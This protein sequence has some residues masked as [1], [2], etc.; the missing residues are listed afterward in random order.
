MTDRLVVSTMFLRR[1]AEG[2]FGF[3]ATSDCDVEVSFEG[4]APTKPELAVL[5]RSVFT[6]PAAPRPLSLLIRATPK[7][8][9]FW[10][11]AARFEYRGGGEL[12]RLKADDADDPEVFEEAAFQPAL[13][14]DFKRIFGF[15]GSFVGVVVYLSRIREVTPRGLKAINKVPPKDAKKW[16]LKDGWLPA[17][18]CRVRDGVHLISQRMLDDSAQLEWRPPETVAAVG[19]HR[20]F[21]VGE[22]KAPRLLAVSWPIDV[23]IDQFPEFFAPTPFLVYIHPSLGQNA[24]IFSGLPYPFEWAYLFFIG[25]RDMT[26]FN[27]PITQSPGAKGVAY[28]IAAARRKAV[29]VDPISKFGPDQGAA[30]DPEELETYLREIQAFMF[31]RKHA[32]APPPLGRVALAA[33]SNGCGQLLNKLIANPTHSLLKDFVKEIY[34]LDPRMNSEQL[35]GRVLA[36]RRDNPADKRV[37]AYLSIPDAAYLKLIDTSSMPGTPFIRS[38]PD[39]LR[40]M[41]VTSTTTW[42]RSSKALGASKKIVDAVGKFG[43]T[44]ELHAATLIVHA[45]GLSGFDSSPNRPPRFKDLK[46][47]L[48]DPNG[49]AMPGAPFLVI[50][51]GGEPTGTADSAGDAVVVDVVRGSTCKVFWS[52]PRPGAPEPK[53]PEDFEFRKEVHTDAADEPGLPSDE[54]ALKMLHNLG[55]ARHADEQQ[56]VMEFQIDIG[57]PKDGLTGALADIKSELQKR[58]NALEPPPRA[59][60]LGR[61]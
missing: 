44:H 12:V 30:L 15:G 56:N 33:F 48:F 55:Y 16:R 5:G 27:D 41:A 11:L 59:G 22:V 2:A 60:R 1:Q 24:A 17:W 52:T 35:V 14:A 7:T 39:G 50:H 29:L 4:G 53:K 46:I 42:A 45:L 8:A 21:E 37:R 10:P 43:P 13:S 20:L 51:D 19:Q 26:W 47:R 31:R 58:H 32:Y 28:Q 25:F 61:G 23:P 18:R 49:K 6:M 40:T 34:L 9:R 38:T 3:S 57:T 54:G 36:W